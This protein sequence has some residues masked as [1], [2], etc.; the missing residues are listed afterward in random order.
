MEGWW[1]KKWGNGRIR[2]LCQYKDGK[3]VTAFIWKP[4]GKKCPVTNVTDGN[5]V[6]VWYNP[7]GTKRGLLIFK[8][9]LQVN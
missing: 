2:A 1:K 4:N 7:N 5:G 3:L 6:S 9:G 8:G